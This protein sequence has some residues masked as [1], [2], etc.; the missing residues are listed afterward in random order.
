M[1]VVPSNL[2]SHS[3]LIGMWIIVVRILPC[4]DILFL[5]WFTFFRPKKNEGDLRLP[6]RRSV[7]TPLVMDC[8]SF[9]AFPTL[10]SSDLFRPSVS[11]R[12]PSSRF[13]LST[14]FASISRNRVF[15]SSHPYG[16][17]ASFGK[18]RSG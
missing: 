7:G 13:Y 17:T 15:L 9:L 16:T 6:R 4:T 8:R 14:C 1:I 18:T 10:S 11:G 12:E 2:A 3:I 5:W